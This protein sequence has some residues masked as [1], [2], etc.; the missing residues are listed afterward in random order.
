MAGRICIERSSVCV[1]VC[2]CVC[3]C[4]CG[5]V[6][7]YVCVNTGTPQKAGDSHAGEGDNE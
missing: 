7:V 2:V 6:G 4:V 3:V 1:Y 5:W